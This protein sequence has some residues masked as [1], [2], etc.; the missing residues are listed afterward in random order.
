MCRMS[1]G[2]KQPG[3]GS[4]EGTCLALTD[5]AM[6]NSPHSGEVGGAPQEPAEQAANSFQ[7]C[8]RGASSALLTSPSLPQES[9]ALWAIRSPC[10]LTMAGDY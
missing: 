1:G 9:P 2:M 4:R 3:E 6:R 5:G 8:T 7:T 10:T